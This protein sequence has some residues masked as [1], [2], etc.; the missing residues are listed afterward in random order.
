MDLFFCFAEQSEGMAT[1]NQL[2]H[3]AALA[4]I[5]KMRIV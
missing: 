3:L 5:R 1:G 4:F 2:D